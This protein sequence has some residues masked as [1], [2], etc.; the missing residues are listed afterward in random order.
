MDGFVFWLWTVA[1][2]GGL[3]LLM[4]LAAWA[5]GPRDNGRVQ[6]PVGVARPAGDVARARPTVV[7]GEVI[8]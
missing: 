1:S 4:V 2:V 5:F 7:D 6:S 8:R 3:M